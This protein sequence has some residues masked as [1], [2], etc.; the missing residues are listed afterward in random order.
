MKRLLLVVLSTAIGASACAKKESPAAAPPP[1]V[2]VAD[3][4]QR[5]QAIYSEWIGTLDGFVNAEIHPKVEGYLLKQAYKE[6]SVVQQGDV[7][8]VI[9]PRQF[10][11]ALGQAKGA[12]ARAQATHAKTKVDVDR[13]T[14]LVAQKAVS[15]QELDNALAAERE[16][17]AA[18]DATKA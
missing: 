14:P 11:A 1:E 8:F 3:V 13:Y 18:V 9:D 6:G 17:A 2:Q 12:L 5:D 4:I 7:L 15:Q 10:Q 16:A